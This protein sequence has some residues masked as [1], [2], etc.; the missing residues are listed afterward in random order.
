MFGRE[1]KSHTEPQRPS[2][3]ELQDALLRFQGRL[4]ARLT[5]AFRSLVASDDAQ[6]RLRAQRDHLAYQATALDIAVGPVP[7]SNVL[8]MVAFVELASEACR[9]RWNVDV[10]GEHGAALSAAFHEAAA[11]VWHVAQ[12]LLLEPGDEDRLR[13]VIRDWHDEN[14]ELVQVAA[15][16]L[17]AFAA[18]TGESASRAEAAARGLFSDVRKGVQA[19]DMARLLGE[20]ALFAVQ[21]MPFLARLQAT[22]AAS[23]AVEEVMRV[24]PGRVADVAGAA[25]ERIEPHARRLIVTGALAA[26]GVVVLG[27]VAYA[28]VR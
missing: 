12:L 5:E 7:E 24:L 25:A 16:R 6:L 27:A 13:H 14:P 15:V 3:A 11:D 17:P 1:D 20:R 8:D 19:A 10:H 21:R 9:S 2:Q 18:I 23:E 28:I 22:I 4:S 26:A